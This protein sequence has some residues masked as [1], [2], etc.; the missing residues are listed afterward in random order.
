M[1]WKTKIL[2]GMKLI[3]QGCSE[4]EMWTDC[5]KCPFTKYCDLCI[6]EEMWVGVPEDWEIEGSE[7]DV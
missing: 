6:D 4:N 7:G 2:E 3:K 1:D 5:H